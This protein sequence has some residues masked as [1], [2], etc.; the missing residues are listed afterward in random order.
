MPKLTLAAGHG[1]GDPGAGGGGQTEAERVRVLNQRVKDLAANSDDVTILDPSRNWYADGGFNSL[2]LPHGTQ[3]LETHRDSDGGTARGA[4]IIIKQGFSPDAYD[5][6]L[7]RGLAAIL[8]GRSDIIVGRSNLANANRCARRGI[9]Y[10]LAEVGFIDNSTD[11]KIFDTKLDDIARAILSAFD[12]PA[13]GS[14]ARAGWVSEGGRWWYRKA[15]G[16]YPKGGWCLIDNR[17]YAFDAGGWMLTG[18]HHPSRGEWYWLGQDGAARF[19]WEEING[20][21]YYFA[22]DGEAG[23]KA[24]QMVSDEWRKDSKGTDYYLT[25]DGSMAKSRWVDHARYYVDDNGLW[26]KSR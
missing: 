20:Q 6:A 16:S 25:G 18:W 10:R 15:D 9:P 7:A 23:Y 11:R 21:W 4:H 17:W 3:L 2:T 22:K 5:Q 1:A 19:G 26:D 24:C 14:A 8:P 13:R 12:I